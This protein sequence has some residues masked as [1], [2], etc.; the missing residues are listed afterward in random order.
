VVRILGDAVRSDLPSGTVTFLFTDI[1]GSTKLLHELGDAYAE[2]LAEHRRV[3][4]EAF[5]AHGGVEVDTQGDAF[6][7]AFARAR[8][9]VAAAE[10]GQRTLAGGPVRVRMGLHTGEPIVGDEGYVGMDVHR[11]ARVMSAGQGGQ[12]VLTQTT[13]DLLDEAVELRD[14]GE[15]RLRDLSAPQR[16]YQLGSAEHPPLRTLYRTNLPVQPNP[17]VGRTAELAALQRLLGTT[18]LLTLVGAGG[19]GKTRLALQLAADVSDEFEDGAFWV[20]LA[21]VRDPALVVP[22]AAAAIG[23]DDDLARHIGDRRMLLLLDNIEQVIECAPEIAALLASTPNLKLIATGREPLRIAAEREY[24]LLPMVESEAV[25]LF[26][27]RA[28]ETE[29]TDVVR[30]ICRRLDSLPLAIELAA[31]RTKLLPPAEILARLDRALPLLTTGP[32]DA[33]E[34]QRTLRATVEWSYELLDPAA[35]DAF[36]K[37]AVF[38]GGWSLEAAEAVVGV[39]V[40]DLGGLVARSLVQR[41]GDRYSML[42]TVREFARERFDER[43]DA[44]TLKRAHATYYRDVVRTMRAPTAPAPFEQGAHDTDNLRAAMRWALASDAFEIAVELIYYPEVYRVPL[45]EALSWFGTLLAELHQLPG[46]D[47]LRT[48]LNAATAYSYAARYE[49]GVAVTER[50]LELARELDDRFWESEALRI[51]GSL[52]HAL[53]SPEAA[54][55][56]FAAALEAAEAT[57]DTRPYYRALH[58]FG[59][60]EREHGDRTRAR[61][62]LV[63]AVQ[64]ALEHGHPRRASQAL[65]G[66]G[67]AALADGDYSK[68]ATHYSEALRLAYEVGGVFTITYCLAGL[69]AVAA[70]AGDVE[71]AGRLWGAVRVLERDRIP[72]AAHERRRYDAAIEGVADEAFEAHVASGEVLSLDEAVEFA[73]SVD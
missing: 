41:T 42:E 25:E 43:G 53:D 27:E 61:E 37:L 66:L 46:R 20:S 58:E 51:L 44:P 19:S 35:R 21:G 65:H 59:E 56:Y 14:L 23:A 67:E 72:L 50:A 62:L 5:V 24:E 60:F 28:H 73:L 57:G 2:T 32:R 13:R 55:S 7:Y 63:Q 9:A 17:L 16:L 33:P 54:R 11:A 45:A 6:F 68:A 48:L 29:P 34:R 10:E 52:S 1:E 39:S 8:D 12:V 49:D 31:A 30:A 64:L 15:H 70:N 3:L 40:D 38:A 36:Q 4:R 18:R 47:A 22:A 71:R 69:A 26:R